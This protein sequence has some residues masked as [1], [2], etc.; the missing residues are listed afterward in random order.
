MTDIRQRIAG[1]LLRAAKFTDLGNAPPLRAVARD[2][3]QLPASDERLMVLDALQAEQHLDVFL[4]LSERAG[5]LIDRYAVGP[6]DA[7][8]L[9]ELLDGLIELEQREF[10]DDL[11]DRTTREGG[12]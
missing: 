5:V 4:P 1:E 10:T 11:I 3:E 7:A 6:N 2:V 12:D 8:T 9:D